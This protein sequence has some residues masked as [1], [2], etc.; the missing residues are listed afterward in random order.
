[1]MA[2]A[3][4]PGSGAGAPAADPGPGT[5]SRPARIRR[6]ETVRHPD[7]PNLLWVI[8]GDDDGI[9]GLGETYYVPG[10]VEAVIHDL[11]APLLLGTEA[12]A[13]VPTATTL[14]ACANFHGHA[15]AELRAFSALDIALWDLAGHRAGRSISR[16]LGGRTRD[17]I[18]A[19]ATCVD[20]GRYDDQSRWLQDAGALARELAA[21]GFAA[22]KVWPWDRFAPQVQSLAS[23]GPAGW[24]AMGPEGH[25]L[26]TAWLREG[27]DVV[28]SIHDAMGRE[29]QVMIEGHS[30]WDLNA[31]LRIC[32]E[33]EGF[34]IGWVEDLIQPTSAADLARLARETR[35]PH[36]V[37]ERL[38]GRHAY[39]DVLAQ[40]AAHVAMVD[41]A[42]TGGISEARVI[43]AM[44]DA[45]HLPLAPHD[46]TG[47]V[48]LAASLQLCAHAPNAMVM[49]V[50]R[51]LLAD[52]YPTFTTPALTL[53]QGWLELPDRPG[54]GL[55]LRDEVRSDPRSIVRVSAGR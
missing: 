53:R 21:E 48:S 39:R 10:A 31:A 11:A 19:Y 49:E 25:D 23:T 27:L 17:S 15:G 3:A 7:V 50:V 5:R 29:M 26:T 41:V 37:S 24:S 18:R 43:A 14:F 32:R 47:P 8:V 51:G 42:W 52:Q 40:E 30:R 54:H 28:R 46:C 36:A 1:M 13:I 20:A 4:D 45:H 35:V 9:T 55:A 33:L 34:E 6:I 2:P 38:M 16:L 22:M 12:D 44:A